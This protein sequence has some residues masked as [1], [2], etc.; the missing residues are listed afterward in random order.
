M[1]AVD[2]LRYEHHAVL[3]TLERLPPDQAETPGVCGVWSVKEIMAHLASFELVLIDVLNSCLNDQATPMLEKFT[4]GSLDFNDSE[5]ALRQ[6]M[7][8]NEVL[9]EYNAAQAQS[10]ALLN[11]IPVAQRRQ[12]GALAWYGAEYDLEDFLV[13]TYYGHK[14]EHSAQIAH[15]CDQLDRQKESV[16]GASLGQWPGRPET[17]AAETI[18]AVERFQDGFERQDLETTMAAMTDDCRFENT[19]PAPDGARH[20]G[21]AAVRAAFADFFATSPQARFETEEI[22]AAGDRAFVRWIYHWGSGADGGHVR[23]V[24]LFHVH[25]GKIAEKLSYVKG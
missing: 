11:Q 5:V 23:G 1:N 17:A 13:Y 14:R 9:A 22:F 25:N 16:M 8:L 10:I 19:T 12:T 20:Q 7:T 6:A 21:Q 15:F 2:Q 4:D 18:A 24:D 3:A